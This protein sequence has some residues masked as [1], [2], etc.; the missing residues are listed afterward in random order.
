MQLDECRIQDNDNQ[1][2]NERIEAML[3]AIFEKV[4]NHQR[5]TQ[6]LPTVRFRW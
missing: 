6:L 1:L 4:K 2:E 5:M 3:V